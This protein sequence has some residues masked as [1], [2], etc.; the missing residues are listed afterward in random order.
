MYSV[1][2]QVMDNP[3]PQTGAKVQTT[4]HDPI[5]WIAAN[6]PYYSITGGGDFTH[7]FVL[8]QKWINSPAK[9]HVSLI[10]QKSTR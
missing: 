9:N 6:Y 5:G 7:E 3:A 4:M 1:P 10:T 2:T 8:L